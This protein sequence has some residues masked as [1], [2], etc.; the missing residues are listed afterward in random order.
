LDPE[1][2]DGLTARWS[3]CV[4]QQQDYS[5][6]FRVRHPG[7]IERWVS[8]RAAIRDADPGEST[9]LVGTLE[10]ITD[11]KQ[12]ED[13]LQRSGEQ[14]RALAERLEAVREEERIRLAREVHDQVGQALTSLNLDVAWLGE[15]LD[16]LGLTTAHRAL[17]GRLE[18]MS[19]RLAQTVST[20]QRI[21]SDLRPGILDDL[22]LAAAIEWQAD[23]F[24][25]RVG[26]TCE[27]RC[28][29]LSRDPDPKRS[30]ALFRVLQELLTNVVRH[31]QA[32]RVDLELREH[33]GT[34]IL[35]VRDNGQGITEE[36]VRAAKSLGLLGVRERAQA[37]GGTV[38]FRG[39]PGQ[40]TCVTVTVPL[41]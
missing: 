28:S 19:H 14:L 41:L 34:V 3:E 36:Q 13:A 16:K 6:E 18:A 23:E 8:V 12:A 21:S 20:V 40:G 25:A 27:A 11:R 37:V 22:G 15:R 5:G 9:G 35:E 1:D 7:G 38:Q 33:A 30:T 2:R 4:R 32:S 10:D 24:A 17:A 31:A 26:L 39:Q 29:P